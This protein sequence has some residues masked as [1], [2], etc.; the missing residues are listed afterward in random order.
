MVFIKISR[1]RG[2]KYA[3]VVSSII[4]NG[5]RRHKTLKYL[6]RYDRLVEKLGGSEPLITLSEV[7]LEKARDYGK[8]MVMSKIAE[9][10]NL[11]SIINKHAKKQNGIDSGTLIEI[12]A[13]NRA[14]EPKSKLQIAPWYEKTVLP[15][16]YGIPSKKLY[17][18]VLCQVLDKPTAQAIFE[19][20]RDLNQV[21]KEKFNLDVSSV[22]YDITSTYFEGQKCVLAKF[23]Y[24]RDH[25]SDKKQIVIGIVVSLDKGIPVYHFVK[26]GNTADVS[27]QIET[28]TELE[29]LGIKKASIVHDRGMTSK[30]NLRLSDKIKYNYI[31]ALNSGTKQSNYWIKKLSDEP[32]LI[33]D[34]IIKNVKQKDETFKKISYQTIITEKVVREHKR[35]KKYVVVYSEELAILKKKSRNDRI[36][37]AKIELASIVG[38]I[39]KGNLKKKITIYSQ[40]KAAIKGLTKY[41]II[42]V[43]EDKENKNKITKVKWEFKQDIKDKEENNDGYFVLICSD[44]T[45]SKLEI[46]AAFKYKC[47]IE[48]I[49]RELKE[50]V[51]LHPLRHWKDMRPEAQVFVCILGYLLRKILKILM[52]EN[53][54]YDSVSYIMDYLE[55]IKTVEMK[56]GEE[57]VKKNTKSPEQVQDLLKI[58]EINPEI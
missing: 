48:A 7:S 42:D 47:E 46:Y 40:V 53:K 6:G 23:G 5:K 38:K 19:I 18:E 56:I 1:A 22:I 31:T 51:M 26:P 33:A 50:T 57:T 36:E 52:N 2:I 15:F 34:K 30:A 13:I 49:I 43:E 9:L 35:L 21:M 3:S 11:K 55:E 4:V 27:T 44:S 17:P 45:K 54:I 20:H 41:F 28:S 16:V 32:T 8:V 58:L 25:R 39:N 24:S 10:L 14:V 29:M 12:L 37:K